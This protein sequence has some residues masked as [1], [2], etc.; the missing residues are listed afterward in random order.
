LSQIQI[1]SRNYN[2]GFQIFFCCCCC[3]CVLLGTWGHGALKIHIDKEKWLLIWWW[4]ERCTIEREKRTNDVKTNHFR[5]VIFF[6]LCSFRALHVVKDY[7]RFSFCALDKK[8]P[9]PMRQLGDLK[10]YNLTLL[11]FSFSK[12]KKMTWLIF[13]ILYLLKA[14]LR[15]KRKRV[16]R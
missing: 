6:L 7:N 12:V 8:I 15:K 2:V 14:C 5:V 3:C 1:M 16:M 11:Y 10:V 4:I 9:S 13:W